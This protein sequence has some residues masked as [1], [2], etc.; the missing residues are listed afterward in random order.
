MT[1][2]V[3]DGAAVKCSEGASPG[4]LSVP[5]DDKIDADSSPLATVQ[6]H[7][8]SVNIPSFGMCKTLNNPQVAAATSAASGALTPQPC[9]PVTDSAWS[10][11]AAHVTLHGDVALTVDSTCNCKWSGVISIDDGGTDAEAV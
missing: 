11:G 5:P 3:T 4:T 8:P 2:L 10:P 6:H 7:L 1:K 9:Q